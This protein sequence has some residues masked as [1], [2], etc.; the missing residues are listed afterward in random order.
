MGCD[1]SALGRL[2]WAQASRVGLASRVG[3]GLA[4]NPLRQPDRSYVATMGTSI[5]FRFVRDGV[6]VTGVQREV[7]GMSFPGDRVP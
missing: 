2:A 4:T 6:R 1:P 5:T 3:V 7:A